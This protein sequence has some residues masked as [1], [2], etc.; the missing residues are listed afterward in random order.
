MIPARHWK[1]KRV[2]VLGLARSGMAA[3]K[4]FVAGKAEVIAWD[5]K[6]ELRQA[7]H[8]EGAHIQD[9]A[10]IAWDAIDGFLL[11]PGIPHRLPSPHP[12]AQQAL[13][14]AVPLLSDLDILYESVTNAGFIGITGAN[15]KSTTTALI[16]HLLHT[17]GIEAQAGGNIGTAALDLN[18]FSTQ[19][20]YVTELSS[21]QLERLQKIELDSAVLLNIQPDHLDR[22]GGMEG[23]IDAK[24]KIFERV[25]TSK[26]ISIDDSFCKAI[27]KEQEQISSCAVI[28]FSCKN[29]EPLIHAENG[30]LIDRSFSSSPLIDLKATPALFA[31]HNWQNAV[32]A[33]AALKYLS[34]ETALLAKGFQTFP[35]LEHRQELVIAHNAIRYVNDSKATNMDATLQA[36]KAFDNIYWIAGGKPKR[37]D[38]KQALAYASKIR[39]VYTIGEAQEILYASLAPALEVIKC[40]TL[41]QAFYQARKDAEKDSTN[42]VILLSPAC[43][44]FDQFKDFE[45]RGKIFKHLI[46]ESLP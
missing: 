38:F 34:L 4:A 17:A 36:F 14:A 18:P 40:G 21:Y 8:Q 20:V 23:Y 30:L 37:D 9:L 12:A 1:G 32:A 35:G 44:S 16:T 43:A 6:E 46:K 29:T 3:V 42:A 5:D 19:G 7:A 11:S 31:E 33:Y 41:P 24:K 26:A 27:A 15:G 28:P 22:H 45:E 13:A 2:A 10:S 39:K 25:K